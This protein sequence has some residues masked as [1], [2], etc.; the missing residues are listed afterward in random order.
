MK[1]IPG[2]A[3]TIKSRQFNSVKEGGTKEGGLAVSVGQP[4]GAFCFFVVYDVF[5]CV[6]RCEC[7]CDGQPVTTCLCYCFCCCCLDVL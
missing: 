5:A 7:L 2:D 1:K 4:V 3:W 6:F